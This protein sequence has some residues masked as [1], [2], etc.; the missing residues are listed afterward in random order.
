VRFILSVL[1]VIGGAL[2]FALVW[3]LDWLTRPR[4]GK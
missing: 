3:F 4:R 2:V 1:Q